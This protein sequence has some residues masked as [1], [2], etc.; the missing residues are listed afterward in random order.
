VVKGVK[1]QLLG[2]DTHSP[3]DMI[4]YMELYTVRSNSEVWFQAVFNEKGEKSVNS[5][6]RRAAG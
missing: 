4:K 1:I 6:R 5:S 3:V 2:K